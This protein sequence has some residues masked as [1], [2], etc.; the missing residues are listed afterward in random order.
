[1]SGKLTGLPASKATGSVKF[2]SPGTGALTVPA[3]TLTFTPHQ[4]HATLR[5]ITCTTKATTRDT[6]VTVTPPVVGTTGPQYKCVTTISDAS[7]AIRARVPM[8]VTSSGSPTTGKTDTVTLAARIGVY[9][10]GATSPS[11][12]SDLQVLGA[13]PGKIALSKAITDLASPVTRVSGRLNLTKAGTDQILTPEMFTIR[14]DLKPSG[15][16]APVP[17]VI[18]CTINTSPAP[19][20]LTINV[21]QGPAHPQPSSSATGNGGQP[22]GTGQQQG[23]PLGLT[24]P[25]GAPNTGGGSGPSGELAMAAGG[26][27]MVVCGGGL[28]F[29]GRRRRPGS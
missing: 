8:T 17:V 3:M 7:S 5:A 18:A 13:Q 10:P 19:V 15:V 4:S 21:A 9:P 25:A 12:S 24:V 28:V 1:V 26:L 16:P 29:I 20:G 6:S 2:P 23:I 22:Q 14:F 27:A 11:F